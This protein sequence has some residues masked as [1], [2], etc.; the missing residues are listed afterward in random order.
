M[1]STTFLLDFGPVDGASASPFVLLGGAE[2]LDE[3]LGVDGQGGVE[4]GGVALA[5]PMMQQVVLNRLLEAFFG[6]IDGHGFR[7]YRSL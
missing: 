4:V 3:S 2:E 7:S 1:V 5:I 6:V